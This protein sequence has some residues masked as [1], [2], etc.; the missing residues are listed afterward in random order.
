MSY[1]QVR[2]VLER[3]RRY[4]R[5]LG[6]L[7]QD[8]SETSDDERVQ[9]LLEHMGRH[10]RNFSRTVARHEREGA[11]GVLNTWLQYEFDK[12]VEEALQEAEMH[13]DPS[14]D[15]V[16]RFSQRI[17]QAFLDLYRQ[18]AQYTDAP[19]IQELFE[20]LVEMEQ[21]KDENYSWSELQF[22]PASEE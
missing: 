11:E 6:D 22:G 1:I 16:I 15:E 3:L 14:I 18:L 7:Y 20:S 5:R 2:D 19:R 17:D 9:L 8:I 21:G 10:E 4:Y 13:A 12:G